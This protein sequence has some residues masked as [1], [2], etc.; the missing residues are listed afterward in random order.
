MGSAMLWSSTTSV[1]TLPHHILSGLL[2][3][4]VGVGS[5]LL[6]HVVSH[7]SSE[8]LLPQVGGRLIMV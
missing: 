4:S 3:E 6:R 7:G 8:R 5:L 1:P 2:T